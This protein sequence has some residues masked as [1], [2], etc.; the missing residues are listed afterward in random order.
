[1]T[2]YDK[3]KSRL[4]THAPRCARCR[5]PMKVRTLFPG[6]N[7]DDVTYRCDDCGAEVMRSVPRPQ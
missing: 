2:P 6:R 1:M 3:P 5:A 7:V 4:E